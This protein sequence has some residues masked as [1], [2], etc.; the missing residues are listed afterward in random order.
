MLNVQAGYDYELDPSNSIAVLAGYG[1]IDYTGAVNSTW[2]Y[3]AALAYGRKITGR[4]ALQVAAGPQQIHSEQGAA[5]F[6]LWFLMAN[7][8][9]TY[10][11]RRSGYTISFAR[12]LGAG[13]GVFLGAKS[14][15]VT[16][17]AHYQFT[18]FWTG[19]VN[20]GYA[21]SEGLE[22]NGTPAAQF[23]NWFIGANIGRHFG[24]QFL[25]NF[26][27]GV[28]RQNNPTICP[29]ANCGINGYQQ[30]F[31]MTVNWHMHPAG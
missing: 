3:T 14:D 12:G 21:L 11:F 9:L 29:V 26:N 23:T 30:N 8:A 19:A 2:D 18:R 16:G 20:G 1:K 24:P 25:L 6:Q 5:G 28:L 31:G 4:L 7:T 10:E 13:G 15:T 27:Y 17:R 22:P